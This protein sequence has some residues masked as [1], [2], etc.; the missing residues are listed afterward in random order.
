VRNIS[1]IGDVL[2]FEPDELVIIGCEPEDPG[3]LDEPPPNILRIGVRT[4]DLMINELFMSDLREFQRINS[5]VREA[6]A[7]GAV[8]HNPAGG[9]PLRDYDYK[10]ILPDRPLTIPDFAA[11]NPAL[12]CGRR[13][14][15]P[16]GSWS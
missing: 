11:R 10:L 14:E 15:S 12:A 8:L 5:L 6:A 1:P 9:Q 2:A 3:A 4:L 13:G 7:Q 16:P